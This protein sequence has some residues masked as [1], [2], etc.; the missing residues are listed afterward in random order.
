M[1]L[2]G[3][4]HIHSRYSYDGT[5][6]LAELRALLEGQGLSF[7]LMTEHTDHITPSSAQE[8]IGEC[9]RM[10][11][12]RFRFV[13]GFEVP[14]LDNHVLVVGAHE[15]HEGISTQRSLQQWHDQGALLVMAHPHR[16]G[17]QLDDFLR[18][19]LDGFEIWNSQYD[20]IHAPRARAVR[21]YRSLMRS[22]SSLRAYASLD[23]H[24]AAHRNG[25]RIVLGG[26][27]LN[28][29][30]IIDALRSGSFSLERGALALAS[31]G[32]V[33]KGNR[34]AV[35]VLGWIMPTTIAL[36]K[37]ASSLL[38]KAGLRSFGFKKWLRS[39]L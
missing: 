39:R 8:F 12:E 38:A 26:T 13:P 32:R 2:R 35:S 9:E 1:A 11:D 30:A 20:G 16:N 14:Y 6:P 37:R 7:A 4:S 5:L 21:L 31:D 25:P 27:V 29:Q 22:R 28:E 24:R 17:F 18:D 33:I 15:Y 23:L 19:T 36:F 34:F 10:S 3:V